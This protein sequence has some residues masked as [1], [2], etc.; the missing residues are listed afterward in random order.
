[1]KTHNSQLKEL[2]D[3]IATVKEEETKRREE[4]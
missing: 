1:M 3:M 2:E 4:Q